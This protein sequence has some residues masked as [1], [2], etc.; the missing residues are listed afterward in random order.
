M[1]RLALVLLAALVFGLSADARRLSVFLP[2]PDKANGAAVIVCPGGSYYWLSR[3]VEGVDVAR[4]LAEA[5]FAAFVLHYRHAGTR[6]FLFG[7]L[8][9]RQSHYPEALDDLRTA[10]VEVR[11][12]ASEYSVDP[13]KVGVM[14]FSAGGHLALN[15]CKDAVDFKGISSY[16]SFAVSVY[17]VVTMSDEPIVH[18]RSR[19]AL[20]GKRRNDPDLRRRLSMELDIPPEM[21]PVLLVNCL[22]DPT[23]DCRNSVVMDNALTNSGIPHKYI[24]FPT[25]GH[26][27]GVSSLQA[28]WFPLFLDWFDGLPLQGHYY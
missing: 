10:I 23:V 13:S 9:I 22:D 21:P 15:A 8:A 17:P 6:Y 27:F 25:G 1:R 4:K 11:R 20:L 12:K 19:K 16:P 5:G 2:E 3:K 18:K 26:G 28:D 7:G 14:G 24:Q